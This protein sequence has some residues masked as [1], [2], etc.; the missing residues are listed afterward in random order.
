[1]V[2]VRGG[3]IVGQ[4]PACVFA[5]WRRRAEGQELLGHLA[6]PQDRLLQ[7]A[8]WLPPPAAPWG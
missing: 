7:V 4:R 6:Q 1:M 3:G 2:P 8:A 5:G